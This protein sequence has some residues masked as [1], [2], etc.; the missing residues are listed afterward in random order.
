MHKA[1]TLVK[2]ISAGKL[3][4]FYIFT[5]EERGH[6]NMV[7]SQ[8]DPTYVRA[9]SFESILSRLS[10]KGLFK[11]AN[12][13]VIHNDKKALDVGLEKLKGAI[14]VGRVILIYDTI[15]S[16]MKFFK[17]AKDDIY[18]FKKLTASQLSAIV[19]QLI[20]CSKEIA[21][22]ISQRCNMNLLRV[23]SECDKLLNLGRWE[24]EDVK[25]LIT[26]EAEDVIFDMI[27]AVVSRDSSKAFGYY[28]DL[29][30]RKES[31]IKIISLLYTSF[32]NTL[33]VQGLNKLSPTEIS[34]STG[35]TAW[36]IGSVKRFIGRF[37]NARLLNILKILQGTEVA[38]K[39]GRIDIDLGMDWL[40]L[41]ILGV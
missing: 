17:D 23:T 25:D 28:E 7:L 32:K 39:T 29:K 9:D 40:L 24:A 35:L 4:N 12:T 36:Q 11:V 18:E 19:R 1:E 21:D 41:E 6:M 8:I 34:A 26:P 33:I 22:L 5:G 30:E 10:S 27:N 16:R 14:N 2:D 37:D 3:K 31:P 15:D 38:M 13:F 20:P